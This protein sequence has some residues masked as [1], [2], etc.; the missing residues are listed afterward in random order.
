MTRPQSPPVL[1]SVI[2][3]LL[4]T[5]TSHPPLLQ[6]QFLALARNCMF[7]TFI[8]LSQ[9][10]PLLQAGAPALP[11]NEVAPAQLSTMEQLVTA[12]EAEATRLLGL[13]LAPYT[14]GRASLGELQTRVKD[15]LVQNTVR[16]DPQVKQAVEGVLRRR[17]EEQAQLP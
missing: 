16:S 1:A 10:G 12:S 8:G 11:P 14:S 2:N 3:P 6:F 15:W 9:L 13:E 7:T 5:F 4:T 17:R